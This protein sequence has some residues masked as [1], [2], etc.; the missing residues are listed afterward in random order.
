MITSETVGPLDR[1]L[2]ETPTGENDNCGLLAPLC[3]GYT[4]T[5]PVKLV[6]T[7]AF[8]QL[9]EMAVTLT[10]VIVSWGAGGGGTFV[11]QAVG[12]SD[13]FVDGWRV[14][15]AHISFP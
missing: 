7:L 4:N 15:L 9:S 14:N 3:A 10:D 2:T 6:S 13:G 8:N 5:V 11:G 1:S 12:E